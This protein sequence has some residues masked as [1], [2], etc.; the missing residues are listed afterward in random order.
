MPDWR[1]MGSVGLLGR[2]VEFRRRRTRLNFS[3]VV[4]SVLFDLGEAGLDGLVAKLAV[5]DDLA[6]HD[7]VHEMG[8]SADP[9]GDLGLD[10]FG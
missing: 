9:G 10:G 8:V 6:S 4:A 5:A 7:L 1:V 2:R 3:A